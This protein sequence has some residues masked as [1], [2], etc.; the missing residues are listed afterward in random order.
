MNI[1]F[2]SSLLVLILIAACLGP[3]CLDDTNKLGCLCIF[4]RF[5]KTNLFQLT[6]STSPG[7]YSTWERL[8]LFAVIVVCALRDKRSP[9]LLA[10]AIVADHHNHHHQDDRWRLVDW[11]DS[12]IPPKQHLPQPQVIFCRTGWRGM[13]KGPP[14]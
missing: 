1:C 5:G 11:F 4:A 7:S 3:L 13:F 12:V 10:S 6:T 8:S 14:S 2:L 9:A